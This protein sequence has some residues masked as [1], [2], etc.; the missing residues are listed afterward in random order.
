MIIEPATGR[1]LETE[2]Q[3]RDAETL[4]EVD[5]RVQYRPDDRLGI[6]VP[7]R[8]DERYIVRPPP[9]NSRMTLPTLRV[10][11]QATYSNFRRFGVGVEISVAPPDDRRMRNGRPDV[12]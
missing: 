6:L 2:L 10:D 7:D 4:L 9:T 12:P 5:V 11:S 3:V 8:M 1:I